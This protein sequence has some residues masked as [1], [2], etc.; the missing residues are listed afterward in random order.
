M[1]G[2]KGRDGAEEGVE[3]GII[4]AP[5]TDPARRVKDV[6]RSSGLMKCRILKNPRAAPGT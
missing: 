3:L 1:E 2:R 5:N 6:E 4:L